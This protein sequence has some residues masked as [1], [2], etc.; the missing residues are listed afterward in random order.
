M[1]QKSKGKYGEDLAVSFLQKLGYEIVERNYRHR[2]GEIDIIAID[3][4]LL[5]FVEVKLRKD[6]GFGQPESF[7]SNAQKRMVIDTA[8]EYIFAINWKKDIRFDIIAI[9]GEQLE[10]IKDAFY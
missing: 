8:E 7:V 5:V 1:D 9:H 6:I 10:H 3:G 2:K 4:K